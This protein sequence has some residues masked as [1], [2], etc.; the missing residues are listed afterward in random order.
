MSRKRLFIIDCAGFY[1]RAFYG[2]RLNLSAPDGTPTNAV[3]AF[4]RMLAKIM[5]GEKPDLLVVALDSKGK[6][7]RHDLYPDYKANR[8]AM[9][10]GL[11]AQIPLIEELIGAYNLPVLKAPGFEADDLIGYAA[12]HAAAAGYN[13]TIFSG[14][15]DMMQLVGGHIALFDPLKE[16]P[17][18]PA[19]VKEKFGVTPSQ[20]TDVLALMGDSSDNIPGVPGI[21]EKTAQALIAEYHSIENLLAHTAGIKKPKLKASLTEHAETARLSKVLATIKTDFDLPLD[22]EAWHRRE[23][24]TARLAAL[25][26]RLGFK[27]FLAELGQAAVP[28]AGGGSPAPRPPETEI[29]KNYRTI[30]TKQALEEVIAILNKSGGFAVDT[31]TTSTNPVDAALVG[32][33]LCAKEGEAWY[34]P[35]GH[36]YLGAPAQLAKAEALKLLKPPLEDA[37]IPKYGQNLKYDIT[38]LAGEGVAVNPVGF[39]T[40]IASYLTAPEERRHGLSYL[41]QRY[42]GLAMIEYEDVTG[43]GAK[44]VTFNQVS[45]DRATEYSAEDADMAFRLTS[46]L[47]AEIEAEGLKDLYYTIEQPLICVLAQMEQNGIK[48]DVPRMKE[49]SKTLEKKLHTLEKEIHAA[50]G[51]EFNIASPKQLSA[52]LFD[53]LGLAKQRKTKTGSSTDQGV[54]ETLAMEHPLPALVL[55]HRVLSKLKST[56]VDPLPGMVSPRTGRIHT[57]FNQAVAATGRLSSSDPNLQNI[58]VRTEEGREIRR[59]FVAENG[60]LLISADYSQIELR[61]LAHLSGDGLLK[62]SFKNDEDIHTRTAR[63]IFGA[64]GGSTPEMRRAAKAVNFGIIYGQT[65]FGLAQELAVSRREAQGYID[66]YFARYRGVREFIDATIKKAR[67]ERVVRTMF[68]RKRSFPEIGSANRAVR[69]MAER[70]A[71]NTVVQGSA[72]DLIK[73]AML[74]IA[75]K[76][77]KLHSKMLLQVHDELIV[78]APEKNADKVGEAVRN[79]MEHAVRLSVPLKVSVES[80]PNWG[81]M[82]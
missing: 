30:F 36:D 46:I 52:I 67:E 58:P 16:R 8:Q 9:P 22:Y 21:G 25:F 6:T 10:D 1:Y 19:E 73:K 24:D 13:V 69:E 77:G 53:K 40:L 26:T 71:V 39:D 78:E 12:K 27:T 74:D 66:S 7:F 37:A 50:A 47:K 3:Y 61:I 18:G 42:L 11:S 29:S 34:L 44:Q 5:K 20:V 81:D 79:L 59:A 64:I 28:A 38:V 45:T 68:G 32:I 43:K 17:I 60:H 65:A 14:D 75:P 35:L 62:E 51:E 54:L 56:Y 48:L 2:L 31:E 76:L 57:S 82:H 4:N 72:A 23:P 55:R 41:A 80:A 63:E 15:K 49:Y 70:M 33:S